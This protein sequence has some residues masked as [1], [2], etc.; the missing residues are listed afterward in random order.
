MDQSRPAP[1]YP[2]HRAGP[3]GAQQYRY[4]PRWREVRDESKYNKMLIFARV[5]PLIRARVDA[6]LGFHIDRT[7]A[8]AGGGTTVYM[9][10][11]I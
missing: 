9:S 8:F 2:S 5:L 10:K 7:E 6:D 3:E 11:V 4:H 1:A